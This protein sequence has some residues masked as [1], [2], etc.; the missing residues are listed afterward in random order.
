MTSRHACTVENETNGRPSKELLHCIHL[1]AK[2]ATAVTHMKA[3]SQ[4]LLD[5][6]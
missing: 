3:G 6:R 5:P 4:E 1:Y 2:F